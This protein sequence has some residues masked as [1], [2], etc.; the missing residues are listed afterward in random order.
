MRRFNFSLLAFALSVLVAKAAD[1]ALA[2]QGSGTEDDPWLISSQADLLTLAN[3]CNAV[4]VD[5]AGH[6]AGKYFKMTADIDMS[7]VRDFY[8]IAT[9]PISVASSNKY[10]FQGIFD[11]QGHKIMSLDI[12]GITYDNDGKAIASFGADQSRKW[13]GL[14]GMLGEGAQVRNVI[15]AD[16]CYIS[17]VN[18]VGGI[19]GAVAAGAL[20]ENCSNYATIVGIVQNTGG[21]AGDVS[22]TAKG[23]PAVVR[24]CFNAG[25]VSI[26]DKN[27]GGIVGYSTLGT[28]ENCANIGEVS[29]YSFNVLK[30]AGLQVAIGGIVGYANGAKI[31]GCANY[32]DVTADNKQAGGIAGYF[33]LS[34]SNGYVTNC[35]NTGCVR[36]R[37]QLSVSGNIVG[38]TGA[39]ATT[40]G[41]ASVTDCYYDAQLLASN[42]LAQVGVG[43]G[44]TGLT[45]SQLTAG[46]A[47]NGLND[48]WKYSAGSYPRPAAISDNTVDIAAAQFILLPQGQTSACF[49]G[50]AQISTAVNGTVGY[51]SDDYPGLSVNGNTVS[52]VAGAVPVNSVLTLENEFLFR[53]VYLTTYDTPFTGS[54]TQAD[55]YMLSNKN[56]IVALANISNITREHWA[57]K[58]FSMIGDID[59][60]GVENFIGIGSGVNTEN[61]TS[62]AGEYFFAGV[63]DGKGY[64][65]SNLNIDGIVRDD[66]GA[67]LAP[68]YGTLHDTGLFGSLGEGAVVRNLTIDSS[69]S[70]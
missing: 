47:L 48:G 26:N 46:T 23:E 4:V 24:N 8:G 54:G 60:S 33:A 32:G 67:V 35:I 20:I 55:P 5:N 50:N 52:A 37:V 57:G 39:S 70:I 25:S 30:S 41:A 6:Y 11:G 44:V 22:T 13:V 28:I 12:D 16:D 43:D 14:F 49:V 19:A 42:N 61:V 59:M 38:D 9:A 40:S 31:S 69:C 10:Q 36:A 34:A 15:I 68:R 51:F 66:D 3:A 1:P 63:F 18:C 17:G 21:I 64:T 56:D 7:R 62:A 53:S 45:T 29:G 2:L 27:A 58:Y 65:L